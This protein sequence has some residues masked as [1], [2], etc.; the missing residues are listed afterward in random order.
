MKPEYI[1]VPFEPTYEM[2]KAGD[3]S[4]ENPHFPTRYKAMLSAAPKQEPLD[5]AD[6]HLEAFQVFGQNFNGMMNHRHVK[7]V[8]AMIDYLHENGRLK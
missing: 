3:F 2:C 8:A 7:A 4:W 1:E 6:L 5:L